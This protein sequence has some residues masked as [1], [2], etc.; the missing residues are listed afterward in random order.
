[1][2]FCLFAVIAAV[3]VLFADFWAGEVL[4]DIRT[5]KAILLLLPCLLF[6]GVENTIKACFFGVKQVR[7]PITS[8]LLEQTVRITAVAVFLFTFRPTDPSMVAALIVCGMIV[9]EICSAVCLTLFYRK[10]I[11]GRHFSSQTNAVSPERALSSR[12][13]LKSI[14]MIAL[15]VA[16]SAILNNF[17]SSA[18]TVLIPKRLAVSGLGQE[19]ALSAFGAMFGMTLPLVSLPTMF[20]GP[21]CNVMTPRLAENMALGNI[22]DVQRKAS[23]AFHLTGLIILPATA[24]LLPLGGIVGEWLFQ[25]EAAAD[26]LP[27]LALASVPL[28]YQMVSGCVLN[29]IGLQRLSVVN[30]VAGGLIQLAFTYFVA[31]NPLFGMNGFILGYF[32]SALF[33]TLFNIHFV[34]R[35]I[36]LSIQWIDWFLLPGLAAGV[37]GT[38]SSLILRLLMHR[39]IAPMPSAVIAAVCG[40]GINFVV[41]RVQGISIRRY[42]GTLIPKSRRKTA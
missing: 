6:T 10:H 40:I 1:L 4:G 15:P 27:A 35:K 5:K 26:Y 22:A 18:D 28:Y 20:M 29:A 37:I 36:H 13:L 8:E 39:G 33:M 16:A 19:G 32:T 42:V 12:E 11:R 38:T 7:P 25:N 17:L 24:L 34:R 3:T 2:F 31:G 23:K 14:C 30:M 9:S 41:L 21:L